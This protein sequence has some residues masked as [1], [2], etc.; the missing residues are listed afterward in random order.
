MIP[1]SQIREFAN[2]L[3]EQ[4]LAKIEAKNSDYAGCWED[5]LISSLADRLREKA[6]RVRNLAIKEMTGEAAVV[7]EHYTREID[8]MMGYCIFLYI[9]TQMRDERKE[10]E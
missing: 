1:N 3:F 4:A 10:S 7:D 8:E 2:E 6:V 9:K 5:S